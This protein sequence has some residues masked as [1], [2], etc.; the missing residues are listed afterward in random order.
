MGGWVGAWVGGGVATLSNPGW[1]PS[2]K[3]SRDST[4]SSADVDHVL[5]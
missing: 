4:F 3:H 1:K 5:P 2:Y